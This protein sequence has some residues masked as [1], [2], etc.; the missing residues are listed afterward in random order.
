MADGTTSDPN[1]SLKRV[2]GDTII[3]ETPFWTVIVVEGDSVMAN[4]KLSDKER[5][6]VNREAK[7]SP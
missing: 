1:I 7:V 4:A 5:A 2:S 6:R 3:L